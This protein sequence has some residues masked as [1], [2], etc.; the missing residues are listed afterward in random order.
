[1]RHQNFKVD[2]WSVEPQ[3][4]AKRL[5]SWEGP[6]NFTADLNGK[7]AATVAAQLLYLVPLVLGTGSSHITVTASEC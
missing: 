1:M 4:E 5:H 7:A 3:N 6:R 2:E